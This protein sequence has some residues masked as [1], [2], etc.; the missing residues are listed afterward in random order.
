MSFINR[1][2]PRVT[3]SV[4]ALILPQLAA[5]ASQE[6]VEWRNLGPGPGAIRVSANVPG[7]AQAGRSSTAQWWGTR[8]VAGIRVGHE[9][10]RGSLRVPHSRSRTRTRTAPVRGAL[11]L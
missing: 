1:P 3:C 10:L 5:A 2:G 8:R 9:G 6:A 11:A 4:P 7:P